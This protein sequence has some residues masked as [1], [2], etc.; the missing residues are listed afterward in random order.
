MK[1]PLDAI[2]HVLNTF[3]EARVNQA[4]ASELAST[5][6][7]YQEILSR[8]ESKGSEIVRTEIV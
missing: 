4:N 1:T 7:H 3:N 5:R 2:G 6:S 8:Y